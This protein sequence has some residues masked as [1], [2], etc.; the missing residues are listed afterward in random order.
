MNSQYLHIAK[1]KTNDPIEAE[2]LNRIADIAHEYDV[3]EQSFTERVN[4]NKSRRG[5]G[6]T[7]LPKSKRDTLSSMEADRSDTQNRIAQQFDAY[8]SPQPIVRSLYKTF[9]NKLPRM[10]EYL[11]HY[12]P[13]DLS[14]GED[15]INLIERFVTAMESYLEQYPEPNL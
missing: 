1:S 11:K 13:D 5:E 3:F 2:M 4:T 6:P 14:L 7:K 12:H 10:R 15:R 8:S 9:Y